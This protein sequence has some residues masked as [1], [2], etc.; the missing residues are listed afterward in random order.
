MTHYGVKTIPRTYRGQN[1]RSTLEARW[2]IFFDEMGI[3][4]VYEPEGYILNNEEWYVPDFY[5]PQFK[6]WA[7]VKGVFGQSELT[8]AVNALDYGAL[9]E[10]QDGIGTTRG[11]LYLG[12][13]PKAKPNENFLAHQHIMFV[14]SKGVTYQKVKFSANSKD[15]PELLIE[16]L[17]GQQT[18]DIAFTQKC[19]DWLGTA[20]ISGMKEPHL[21]KHKVSNAYKTASNY[22]FF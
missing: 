14:H 18:F 2:A 19:P 22:K 15:K 4:W 5:L 8:T 6:T 21:A 1:F 3:E 17:F 10:T 9:P 11:L 13:V 20:V 16:P 7:E 12:N